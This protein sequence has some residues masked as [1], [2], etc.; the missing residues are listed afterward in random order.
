MSRN[1][2]FIVATGIL[3]GIGGLAILLSFWPDSPSNRST[4][5]AVGFA[6]TEFSKPTLIEFTP[7]RTV[8]APL[9]TEFEK[10]GL[11][12]GDGQQFTVN[13]RKRPRPKGI[14]GTSPREFEALQEMALAGDQFAP[15]ILHGIVKSCEMAPAND[16]ALQNEIS[17]LEQTH[18]IRSPQD[19]REIYIDDPDVISQMVQ[20]MTDAYDDCRLL[21]SVQRSDPEKWLEL[22]AENG[23][24]VAMVDLANQIEDVARSDS[25]HER[26]W[27]A[28]DSFGLLGMYKSR[29]RD[30][31]SGEKPDGKVLAYATFIAYS[32]LTEARYRQPESRIAAKAADKVKLDLEN[33]MQELRP[34]EADRAMDM[35]RE[36]ISTNPNC[37]YSLQ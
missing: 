10:R 7:E 22:A 18:R 33:K 37:C 35:A 13:W 29:L 12:F 25:L 20:R 28:G 17:Q 24:S 2:K 34:E 14:S 19:G 4:N 11:E 32:I 26:S 1:F 30:F 9:S 6:E 27:R 21:S 8:D 36:I 31:D 16:A 3:V 23:N 15:I 5:E